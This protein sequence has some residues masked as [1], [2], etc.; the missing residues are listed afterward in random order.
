MPQ[1]D[2]SNAAEEKSPGI[3]SGARPGPGRDPAAPADAAPAD[4]APADVAPADVAP[5]TVQRPAALLYGPGHTIVHG[6]APFRALFGADC[7]GLPAA[8]ALIDLPRAAFEL[9]DLVYRDGRPLAGAVALR[10]ATWR[11]T[12]GERRDI[13]TGEVY[14]IAIRLAPSNPDEPGRG[15]GATPRR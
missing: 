6:N 8:E 15:R 4:V 13:T 11:L 3:T 1:D 5:R 2:R 14:G 7:L 12:I 10:G 9:M